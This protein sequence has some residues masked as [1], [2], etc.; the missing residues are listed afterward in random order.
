MAEYF[1]E[2]L[3]EEIPAWMHSSFAI[4]VNFELQKL[5]E[6]LGVPLNPVPFILNGTPR[7]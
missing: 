4:P 5:Y 1:F 2:L 6:Q 3:L 7:N